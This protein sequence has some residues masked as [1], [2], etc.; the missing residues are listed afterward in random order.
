M[1]WTP[2]EEKQKNE[3]K[4]GVRP[5]QTHVMCLLDA[6][7][8]VPEETSHFAVEARC[9]VLGTEQNLCQLRFYLAQSQGSSIKWPLALCARR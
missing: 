3:N 5:G 1:V 7:A 4:K 6:N 2:E 9:P 8:F